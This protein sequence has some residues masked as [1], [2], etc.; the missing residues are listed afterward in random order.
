M[1]NE[2]FISVYGQIAMMF[3]G[4]QEKTC[5]LDPH[6]SAVFIVIGPNVSFQS[7]LLDHWKDW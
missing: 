2:F 3:M 1:R 7:D 6:L 5:C 4:A